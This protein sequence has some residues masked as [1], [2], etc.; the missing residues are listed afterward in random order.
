MAQV[1]VVRLVIAFPPGG[2]SDI[3]ARAVGEQLGKELN[4]RVII[5]NRPGGNR[6]VA[7]QFVANA[8]PDGKTLWLTTSGAVAINPVSTPSCLTAPH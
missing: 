3:L 6:A 2:S 1:D 5:D 4:Q 7:A 8:A